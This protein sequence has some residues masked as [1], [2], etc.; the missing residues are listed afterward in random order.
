MGSAS[1]LELGGNFD[2]FCKIQRVCDNGKLQQD[3]LLWTSRQLEHGTTCLLKGINDRLPVADR[4]W[5]D[6][7]Q[8]ERRVPC[9]ATA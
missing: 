5:L 2:D 8:P 6:A 3:V 1:S 4:R 7:T 9:K